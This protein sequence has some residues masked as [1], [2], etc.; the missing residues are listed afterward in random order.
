M[1]VDELL[2][3]HKVWREF[4]NIS[5]IPRRTGK[6]DRICEFIKTDMEK[7]GYTCISD[8]A[9]NLLV[10][11][12]NQSKT[13]ILL[14]AHI[15]MVCERALDSKHDFDK[16]PIEFVIKNEN[17]ID[18]L[19]ANGTTL[20]ADDGVGVAAMM[21]LLRQGKYDNLMCFFTASE[22]G[23]ILGVKRMSEQIK[24]ELKKPLYY[25]N[26][27]A[28]GEGRI[29]TGCASAYMMDITGE[30]KREPS[31][32]K[33]YYKVQLSG[34]TG[35]HS[36]GNAGKG[37]GNA[38]KLIARLYHELDRSTKV[39][40]CDVQST[41]NKYNVIPS[42]ATIVISSDESESKLQEIVQSFTK[43][44]RTELNG[45]TV[46]CSIQ[47]CES[48]KVLSPAS[49]KKILHYMMLLPY[50]SHQDRVY[51]GERCT[52]LSASF[53]SIN[54]NESDFKLCLSVR[55]NIKSSQ[56]GLVTIIRDFIKYEEDKA[57]LNQYEMWESKASSKLTNIVKNVY[58][59]LG[60][61]V[62]AAPAH[63]WLEA[64]Y[65]CNINP[66]MDI[67]CIAPASYNA[68]AIDEH[69]DIP[70]MERF[71]SNLEKILD[72]LQN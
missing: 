5:Q 57:E 18:M 7:L 58:L 43:G 3:R 70:S 6:E 8:S 12:K 55:A 26:L 34:L 28:G 23:G 27:D 47:K 66:N 59:E 14:Q 33:S 54:L 4:Y 9:Y 39:S 10:L 21:Y 37:F 63:G 52:M 46:E 48:M 24:S 11:P 44:A 51:D 38:L 29:V 35:G 42:D 31:S 17:G 20:G 41:N 72:K 50:G 68:H 19:Y 15:D 32:Y 67:V 61:E 64:A 69:L 62:I 30:L 22:E 49:K 60:K 65:L 36:G 13:P 40:L 25:M 71:V 53:S 45:G 16:D 56:D 2:N 1:T